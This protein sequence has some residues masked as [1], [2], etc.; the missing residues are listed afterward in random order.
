MIPSPANLEVIIGKI[1]EAGATVDVTVEPATDTA[2]EAPRGPLIVT[3][4]WR[5]SSDGRKQLVTVMFKS[6]KGA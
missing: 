3:S 1:V 4:K 5:E 6:P 2:V